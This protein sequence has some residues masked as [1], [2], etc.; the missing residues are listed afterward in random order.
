VP[1]FCSE[2]KKLDLIVTKALG[3]NTKGENDILNIT[4]DVQDLLGETE[5]KSGSVVLFVQSS[6]SSLTIMEYE[7]GLIKDLPKTMDRIAPKNGVYEHEKAW[8]D[9]NGHSHMRSS[10]VEQSLVV[11][12][13]ERTLLLGQWQQI[14][15][16]E[17]D[18]R[19]RKRTVIAQILGD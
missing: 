14:I 5:V 4:D 8:N 19:P 9:G 2:E 11:P 7:E 18:V 16:A 13:E 10:V 1:P 12:F 3:F 15:L 17:F 6:T